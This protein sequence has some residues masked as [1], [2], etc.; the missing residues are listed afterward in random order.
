MCAGA[1]RKGNYKPIVLHSVSSTPIIRHIKVKG[2]A[3]PDDPSLR[4]Y[5]EH[6]RTK[7]GS[8]TWAK[9]SKLE[10]VANNQYHKCPVCGESLYNGEELET[11][12]I[13]PVKEGGSDDAENLIHLHKACHK[14]VHTKKPSTL[15]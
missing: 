12:H 10:R 13:V 2:T 15:A 3:S 14:Q 6:R 9:G 11:H 5:W 7:L 8:K 1:D 4:D